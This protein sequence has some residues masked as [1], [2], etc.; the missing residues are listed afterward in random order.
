MI[1]ANLSESR[2]SDNLFV[3]SQ[4]RVNIGTDGIVTEGLRK[5][6]L[7]LALML[8][9]RRKGSLDSSQ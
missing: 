2:I 4:S 3:L 5:T 8:G 7:V 6:L 1:S 9:A